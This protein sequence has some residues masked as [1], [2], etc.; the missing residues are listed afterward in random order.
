MEQKINPNM[1]LSDL[2]ITD[3]QKIISDIV[4]ETIEDIFEDREALSSI[5]YINSIKEARI[6]YK[7]GNFTN[8]DDVVNV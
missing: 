1:K 3:L 7:K 5:N 4:R 8:L 6:E 2:T